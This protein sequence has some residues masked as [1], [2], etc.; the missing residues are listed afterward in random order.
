MSLPL[1]TP[2]RQNPGSGNGASGACTIENEK[3]SN[4]I[5][6]LQ[7]KRHR[8]GLLLKQGSGKNSGG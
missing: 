8:V 2:T 7:T 1:S 6:S 4:K 5:N 3:I